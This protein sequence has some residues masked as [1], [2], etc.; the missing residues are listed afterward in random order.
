VVTKLI[1]VLVVAVASIANTKLASADARLDQLKRVTDFKLFTPNYSIESWN[2]E[3]KEPYPLDLGRPITKVRLHYFDKTGRAYIFGIE[4]HKAVGYKSKR[5]ETNIDVRKNKST[6]KVK[7]EVFKFD[8]SG[9]IVKFNGIEARFKPWAGGIPGG[10]LRWIQQ[11]TYI[12][13]DSSCLS[14][15]QMVEIA[16]SMN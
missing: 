11:G 8:A 4:Q 5:Y 3:I 10:Y 13:I 15:K 7:E 12:E 1:L 14:K 9:E 16:K 2:I 6:T